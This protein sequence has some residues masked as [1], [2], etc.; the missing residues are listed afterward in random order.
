MLPIVVDV[1]LGMLGLALVLTCIRLLRGPSMA[2]R[3]VA[4]DLIATLAVGM[5]CVYAIATD[6]DV[7]LRDAIVLAVISFLGTTAFAYYL[8]KGGRP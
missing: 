8:G 3:V 7:Y 2:D 5:I 1:A 4:L 6:Q